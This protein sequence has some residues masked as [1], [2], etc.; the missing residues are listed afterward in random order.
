MEKGKYARVAYRRRWWCPAKSCIMTI[1]S[2]LR[3]GAGK[4]HS[5]QRGQYVQN[6]KLRL[7][8]S[9]WEFWK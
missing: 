1:R 8:E 5:R 9:K 4:R 2:E 7:R 6:I 3:K